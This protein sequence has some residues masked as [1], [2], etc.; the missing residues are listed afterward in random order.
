VFKIHKPVAE[1][2]NME[3]SEYARKIRKFDS[4]IFAWKN[5]SRTYV[6]G[7]LIEKLRALTR[8]S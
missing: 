4:N 2:I 7:Y 8:N 1:D 3:M 5:P 6:D